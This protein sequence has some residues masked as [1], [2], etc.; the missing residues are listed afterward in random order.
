[1]NRPSMEL[2]ASILA[3][4]SKRLATS[5]D[6][7]ATRIWDV[8]TGQELLVLQGH[9][10]NYS[11]GSYIIGASAVAFSPNGAKLAAGGTDNKAMVW[12][13]ESGEVLL[14]LVDHQGDISDVVFSP[15]GTRLVTASI[16]ATAKVWD[17]RTGEA[18]FTLSGHS[19]SLRAIAFDPDG[20]RNS[21]HQS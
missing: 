18:L 8:L 11:P 10:T 5:G 2:P 4:D 6:D 3:Q 13:L 1:M 16:D 19:G 9:T 14:T 12:D 7:G 15:D 21:D 20:A 17:A